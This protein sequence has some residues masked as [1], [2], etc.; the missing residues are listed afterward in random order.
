MEAL[1][2]SFLPFAAASL[3]AVMHF[4]GEAVEAHISGYK[5]S[6]VSFGSGVSITYIFL[7][8]LPEFHRIASN[9]S[10]IIF[11]F[12]LI[13]FSSMHLLEKYIAKSGAEKEFIQKEYGEV[14]SAFLFLY[15]GAMGYLVASLLAKNTVSGVLFLLPITLHVA[16]NSLSISEL[17]H[18]MMQKLP[19]KISISL[20]PVLGMLLH[21]S[22]IIGNQLFNPV[23]GTVT[24]IFFYVVIRDSIPSGEKGQPL[25]YLAGTLIY[26]AVILAANTI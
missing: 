4:M 7:Q 12:P 11:A 24:G 26:L 13:G 22:G 10:Q 14:H 23:F 3:L 16:V 19:V 20:A 17:H 1:I 8:L 18:E 21:Y 6:I 5:E 2:E 9:T 25:E 15:H